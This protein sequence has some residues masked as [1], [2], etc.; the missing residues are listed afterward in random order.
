MAKCKAVSDGIRLEL[1]PNETDLL[2][3]LGRELGRLLESSGENGQN[4][5]A[6]S[7]S[8]QR[9][10]DREAVLGDLEEPMEAEL[11]LHRLKRIESVQE[12]LLEGSEAGQALNVVLDEARSDV[13]LA[14][15]ADLRL[16]LAKV[17]GITPENPVP[18]TELNPN[19]WTLE[20]K[21]YEFL[22]VLQEWILDM[23]Q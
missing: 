2:R 14:Y 19:D 23:L 13:W 1:E 8:R 11:L 17:I 22:S 20:M 6:F 4:L 21:M 7:P 18:F 5:A 10:A 15:L 9:E 3:F 16:L 12:E